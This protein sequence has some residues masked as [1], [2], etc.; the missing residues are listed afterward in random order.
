M[1]LSLVVIGFFDAWLDFRFTSCSLQSVSFIFTLGLPLVDSLGQEAWAQLPAPIRF[2]S[3][4]NLRTDSHLSTCLLMNHSLSETDDVDSSLCRRVL[5]NRHANEIGSC[6][7]HHCSFGC[8]SRDGLH[9]FAGNDYR[10]GI[11]CDRQVVFHS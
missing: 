6:F 10:H 5:V 7:C 8:S 4:L 1:I 9:L 2:L 11:Y 3:H